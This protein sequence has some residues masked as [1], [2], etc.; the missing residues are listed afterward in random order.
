MIGLLV[1]SAPWR[2][3]LLRWR[4]SPTEQELVGTVPPPLRPGHLNKLPMDRPLPF[5]RSLPDARHRQRDQL[6]GQWW[7]AASAGG[8]ATAPNTGRPGGD[9]T[10][11]NTGAPG[12]DATVPNTGARGDS[13]RTCHLR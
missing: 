1:T 3:A 11:P 13:C 8:D 5:H 4:A 12:G 7:W 9:A 10:V 2:I 6:R